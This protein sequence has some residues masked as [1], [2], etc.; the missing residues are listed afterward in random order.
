MV[1]TIEQYPTKSDAFKAADVLR[2]SF[3]NR[4]DPTQQRS[5]SVRNEQEDV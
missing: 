3:A 1:G 4:D 2:L 5:Q